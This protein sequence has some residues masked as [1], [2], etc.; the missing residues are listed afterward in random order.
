MKHRILI[1]T[2][3]FVTCFTQKSIAIEPQGCP[4]PSDEKLVCSVIMCVP[5]LLISESRSKCIQINRKFAIYLATLGFWSKPPKCKMRDLNCESTGNA[6]SAE[7]DA[8]YCDELETEAEQN[9]CRA[10]LGEPVN[11]DYCDS[12]SGDERDA[13]EIAIGDENP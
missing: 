10:A 11:E 3:L 6:S 1:T 9:S 12:F 4:I 7:I 13:C 8:S 5:G 2:F